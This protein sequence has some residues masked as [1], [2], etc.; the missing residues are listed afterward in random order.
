MVK[1]SRPVVVIS[2]EL[3]GRDNL[4]TVVALSTKKPN[5]VMDYHYRVPINSMPQVGTFQKE[6]SWLKG[7]M[8]YTVGFHRLDLIKLGSR[9]PNT[10]KR[11]YFRRCLSKQQMAEIYKCV[12]F[13]LNLGDLGQYL[14]YE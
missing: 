3:K 12:L 14:S 9:N 1:A 2:P 7:D 8:I 11:V 10:G 6:E 13:G 5:S 4:V